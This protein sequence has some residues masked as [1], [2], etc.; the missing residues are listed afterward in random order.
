MRKKKRKKKNN[1]FCMT[2]LKKVV[3]NHHLSKTLTGKS[4]EA[5]VSKPGVQSYR[6]KVQKVV[7]LL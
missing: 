4:L 7:F 6:N 2:L 5:K 3:V 1:W